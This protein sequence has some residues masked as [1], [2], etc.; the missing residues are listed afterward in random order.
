MPITLEIKNKREEIS[1]VK[2]KIYVASMLGLIILTVLSILAFNNEESSPS[3]D[4]EEAEFAPSS[5]KSTEV[6]SEQAEVETGIQE[7]F[8]QGSYSA[9]SPYVIQNPYGTMPLTA[10]L[11]FETD[12]PAKITITIEGKENTRSVSKTFSD[13][14]TEHKI[15]V[16]GLY[17]DYDN[18][19]DIQAVM[20]NGDTETAE[21]SIATDPLPEDFLNL[22]IVKSQP[23][24]MEKG[25][26]FVI[27][28]RKYPYAVDEDGEV[29]WYSSLDTQHVF[30][31]LEN[32]NILIATRTSG[33]EQ[34]DKL[35]E[36]DLLGKVINQYVVT[37]E[38]Y[39]G[40]AVIHHDAIELPNGN[41]LATVHDGPGFV[42]DEMIEIN[43][44]TGETVNVIDLKEIFPEEIYQE[45]NG[46][47]AKDGEI[48]WFHQNSVAYDN[49]DKSI[50]ISGRHQ[51]TV[52]KMQYPS[53]EIVWVLAAPEGWPE[54]GWPT[55]FPTKLLEAVDEDVKFPG[56]QH[57]AIILPDQDNNPKTEDL[58]LFDNN[59][60]VTRG[61]E[62][63][64]ETFS[65]GVQYR[66]DK[67]ILSVDEIWSYG[68]ERGEDFYSRIVGDADLL[69][70]TG[71]RL[72]TSGYIHIT[73][74]DMESRIVEVTKEVP[75]E[76]VFELRVSGFEEGSRVQMYRA[77]RMDL[78][79]EE[80]HFD[81]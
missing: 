5:K 1:K 34:F 25:L 31:R 39:E 80:W 42:E 41:I 54:G 48:D 57:A 60:A 70:S 20:E 33:D 40:P 28:S 67:E 73:D 68:E 76:V 56:G 13:Y 6:A 65:R 74:E 50:V 62:K 26:T 45:Y 71:N 55:D 27:P 14:H 8:D 30:E 64:S 15:P 11:L 22:E 37:V 63:L 59:I 69:P 79:P 43:R 53:E 21:I 47:G 18:T 78:Y 23:E 52:F 9:D 16:A 46:T 3:P 29:R 7:Q 17:A 75:A 81:W 35:F 44:K 49:S 36:I 51:D 38:G 58:L 10:L 66:I 4:A 77:K 12:E 61:N 19:V 24:K 32:G 72:I 2:K